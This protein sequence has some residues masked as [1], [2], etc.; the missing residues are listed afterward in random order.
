[1]ATR[2]DRR[3]EIRSPTRPDR[4]SLP[5]V[6]SDP[7]NASDV[8]IRAEKQEDQAAVRRVHALAF[9]A[10]DS[11]P[12]LVDALR[13]QDR[14][15][16]TLGLV[17]TDGDEVVGHVMLSHSRLDAPRRLVDVYVLSPLGVLP[18]HQRRGIGTRLVAAALDTARDSGVPLVF[19]EGS[20]RYY[21]SRGFEPGTGS[22][23]RAPSLRIPDPGFQVAKMPSYEPW[24][25][26]ALVYSETFWAL[27][28][29]GL[30]D[31]QA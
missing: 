11:V 20:P 6:T 25:T 26:G 8:R 9:G 2:P 31:P 18:D 1:V 15:L 4:P 21:G 10:Q 17:A 5:I 16:P 28:C 19:L 29:V 13:A 22:G 23:F 7:A 3:H 14:P 12:D 30:R 27:D 24:M